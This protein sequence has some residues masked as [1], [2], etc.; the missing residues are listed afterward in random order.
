MMMKRTRSTRTRT[1]TKARATTTATTPEE[2]SR[3]VRL[4]KVLAAA[5]VASRREAERMIQAG[6]ISVNGRIVTELGTRIEPALDSVKVDGDSVGRAERAVY[7]LLHKP[8]GV[9]STASDP[10]GRP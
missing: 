4:Q 7:Y 10:K 2:A 8:R 9:L 1:R 5:G 3:G 6:R